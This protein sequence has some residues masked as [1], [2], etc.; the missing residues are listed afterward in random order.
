MGTIVIKPIL[1]RGGDRYT[2]AGSLAE[3]G[4]SRAPGCTILLSPYRESDGKFRTGLDDEALY[5]RKMPVEEQAIEKERVKKLKQELEYRSGVSLGPR[6]DY[7]MKMTDGNENTAARAQMIKLG[8]GE[9]AFNDEDIQSAITAAWIRVHPVVANS[10]EAWRTGSAGPHVLFYVSDADA[11]TKLAYEENI[12][13]DKIIGQLLTMTPSSR[14]RLAR[15]LEMPVSE[16]SKEEY[17][18]N[19]LTSALKDP[20]GVFKQ[21]TFKGQRVVKVMTDLLSMKE[22]TLNVKDL[23]KQALN[24]GVYR[25]YKGVI[26]EGEL[27]VAD[28]EA[29]L[30]KH[31]TVTTEDRIALDGKLNTR[32]KL[33]ENL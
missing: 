11:E 13:S 19:Q 8:D 15:I 29:D 9:R 23:V 6:D 27:K 16:A 17:V 20:S 10:Y 7:Y 21:G 31:L 24:M 4:Y 32:K 2:L 33:Q 5:I 3:N 28:S 12:A 14:R 1:Q 25:R 26:M 22:E 30:V 18:Y